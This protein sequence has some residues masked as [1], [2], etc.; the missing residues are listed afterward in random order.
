MP[1]PS[2][3]GFI[4]VSLVSI[5]VEGYTASATG[6]SQIAL[7]QLH[8]GC[9]ERIR[10]KKTCPVHGE[11]TS[12][13]IVMGYQYERDQ[14]AIV[15]PDEIE[16]LRSEADRSINVD[17]FVDPSEVDPR[18]FAGKTYY[19]IPSGAAGQ[20]PYALLHRAI[21]DAGVVGL[22]QVVISNR[23][24]LVALR[25]IDRLLA[26][27]VLQYAADVK[28]VEEFEKLLSDEPVSAQELK[29]AK[30][31]IAATRERKADLPQYHDLYAE[32]LRELVEANVEGREVVKSKSSG[33]APPTINLIDA[34][35]ASLEFKKTRA[36]ARKT[37]S[38]AAP[39]AGA[40][41][42]RRATPAKKRKTG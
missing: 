41:R 22:A 4:R 3:K 30:T 35:K 13:E 1:R 28:P 12:D 39:R 32:R 5:P 23:E 40:S 2:W 6:E 15:D 36:S 33:K 7:N 21:V 18:F 19:L 14:Y 20:K 37:A 34:L 31:L 42:A 8:D 24:Q 25:P 10:Y 16:A 11:V 26:A 17:R 29:L 9:G 38:G 27:S